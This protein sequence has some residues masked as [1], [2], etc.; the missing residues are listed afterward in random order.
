[1]ELFKSIRFL[2]A[3]SLTNREKEVMKLA[4]DD[5]SQKQIADKLHISPSTVSTHSKNIREKT[6]TNN[7]LVA[8]IKAARKGLI[9]L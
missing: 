4:M 7:L 9:N 6:K 2:F 1:M 3:P 8:C 5:Y